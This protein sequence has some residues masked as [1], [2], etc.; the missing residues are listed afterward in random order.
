[1]RF[2]T[3]SRLSRPARPRQAAASLM[4]ATRYAVHAHRRQQGLLVMVDPALDAAQAFCDPFRGR[5]HPARSARDAAVD[6]ALLSRRKMPVLA[7]WADQRLGFAG[8]H[9]V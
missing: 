1:M 8:D 6:P 3:I 9:R 7:G 5:R 2:I 4:G